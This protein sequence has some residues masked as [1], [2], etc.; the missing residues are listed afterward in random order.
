MRSHAAR[1]AACL[2]AAGLILAFAT[3]LP[4]AEEWHTTTSL[5][6]ESKYGDDFAH[7]DHVNPDAPKGGTL[8]SVTPGTFDSFNPFIVRGTA[9]AGLNFF[10]GL[11]WDTLMQQSVDEPGVSH[12]LIAE[13][14]KYPEDY[15]SATYRLDPRARWHDGEPITAEDV[16]WSFGVLKEHSPNFNRYFSSVEKAEAVSEREIL[17]TFDQTG[18]RELP[19][20]LGDMPVLPKHWWQ[21]TDA[22]GKARDVT[23]PTLEPPLGSG[24][25][26][27][28]SFRP[29]AE[30]I[31]ERVED[32]WAAEHPV[33]VGRNNFDRRRYVY[34]QDQNAE[35]QAF[36]KGGLE[37]LRPESSSRRWS[38]E[39]NFPA[40]EAG[41]VIKREFPTE[42][43]EPMQGFV[44]NLR[45]PQFQ[46]RKVRQALT[47]ALDFE[48]MNRNLFYGKNTRTDSYFEGGELAS[49]GL[50]QGRELEILEEFR[51]QLP[52]EVFTEEFKLPVYDSPQAERQHLR[53]AVKLFAEAGWVIKGGKLV[54]EKT[55]EQ[56][57]IEFLGR[58][59][60]DEIITG[61]YVAT[62]RKLGIDASLRI[63][64]PTQYINRVR[65]YE[66]DSVTGQFA[67]SLSPGNEQRE[68][69]GSVA[70]DQ[71]GSRNLA[72]IENP[73]VDALVE[74][75]IYARDRE[76]LIAATHALDR[77]L[78]W[79]FYVVPQWHRPVLWLAYWNK[80]GIPDEQPGYLGADIDSWWIDPEKEAVLAKK[81]SSQN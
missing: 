57:S 56:F 11:L 1:R 18:N 40:F 9:A 29:G 21:G 72:G 79:N 27:I 25:Y 44:L 47:I 43:G 63:V 62:L 30:I 77:V 50:P 3:N 78:L 22:K 46:D 71:P 49:S 14:Y 59:P 23:Q 19:H 67:Q 75:V 24:A 37:D 66:F 7:Y 65:G 31:W 60:T 48:S 15:S 53:Q 4:A 34:I 8:N 73:V 55:G 12:P 64:D 61:S 36:T 17:F 58:S 6:G 42:R 41:D 28:E 13:A 81:Y 54:S 70:A 69:W 39:Y 38:V 32:Y 76:E 26:K 2:G 74:K 45:R 5:I 52:P 80:F 51:D 35:W 10:G 16:V 68:F 20:I 33:N